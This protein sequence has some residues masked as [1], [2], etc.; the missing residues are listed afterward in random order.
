[1]IFD[2]DMRRFAEPTQTEST[3]YYTLKPQQRNDSSH[4]DRLCINRVYRTAS[5]LVPGL[6]E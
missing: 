6:V 1:M 3:N 2:Y 4:W 5:S